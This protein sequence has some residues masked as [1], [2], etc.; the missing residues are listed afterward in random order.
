MH[1]LCDRPCKHVSYAS[2]IYLKKSFLI[3][4]IYKVLPCSVL[5]QHRQQP[6]PD[7]SVNPLLDR[8]LNAMLL[9]K[10]LAMRATD[11]GG[12]HYATQLTAC[13][14]VNRRR[15]GREFNF[16]YFFTTQI[17][18]LLWIYVSRR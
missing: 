3:D 7:N 13:C 17:L 5:L 4:I 18:L 14:K 1:Q 15:R 2:E 8:S 12:Q 11:S 16:T 10:L 6:F 9:Q